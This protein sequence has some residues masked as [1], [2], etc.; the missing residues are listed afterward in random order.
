MFDVFSDVEL[1]I[2]FVTSHVSTGY[3][4][5]EDVFVRPRHIDNCGGSTPA[6]WE[7]KQNIDEFN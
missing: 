2:R 3:R 6:A 4:S 5:N 7:A 1:V